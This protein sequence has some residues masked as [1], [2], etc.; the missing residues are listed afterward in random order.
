MKMEPLELLPFGIKPYQKSAR[1]ICKWNPLYEEQINEALQLPMRRLDIVPSTD[2]SGHGTHVA[3]IAAGNG[4]A[5]N[6]RFRGIASSS[7]LLIVK[8]GSSVGIP[9]QGHH[10]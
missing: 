1:R 8:L 7:E 3:G 4:R 9:F 6:G 5:S 10:N 2:L